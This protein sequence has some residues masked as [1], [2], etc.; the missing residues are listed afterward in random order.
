MNNSNNLLEEINEKL[1]KAERDATRRGLTGSTKELALN[2]VAYE[3]LAVQTDAVISAR[4][5]NII[6]AKLPTFKGFMQKQFQNDQEQ[7][8]ISQAMLKARIKSKDREI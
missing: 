8:E 5:L 6:S 1:D 2:R 7:D 4:A 3:I